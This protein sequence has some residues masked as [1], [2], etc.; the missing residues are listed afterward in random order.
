MKNKAI[1]IENIS[2]AT[3]QFANIETDTLPLLPCPYD[4]THKEPPFK[5]LKDETKQKTECSLDNTIALSIPKPQSEK[6]KQI[7][8]KKFLIGLQK[9]FKKNDNWTFIQPLL[10]S[11]EYCTRCSTC[12][13]SCHIYESSGYNEVYRPLFRSEILR[14]IVS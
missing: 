5:P 10:L 14:R 2:D 6:E 4:Q 1:K 13:E 7:L 3:E 9:L 12:S 8:I 11:M